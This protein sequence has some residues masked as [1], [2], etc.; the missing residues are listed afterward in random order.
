M[1][2]IKHIKILHL[3]FQFLKVKSLNF[4]GEELLNSN[5]TNQHTLWKVPSQ[6]TSYM[7]RP[8]FGPL[9]RSI[10]KSFQKENLH[11]Y[12]VAYKKSQCTFTDVGFVE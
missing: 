11:G 10:N 9:S 1:Q 7:F 4:S 3:I 12:I 6:S 5:Q 8:L 2:Y